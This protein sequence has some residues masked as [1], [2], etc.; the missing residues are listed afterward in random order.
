MHQPRPN[1]LKAGA[2]RRRTRGDRRRSRQHRCRRALHLP[3]RAAAR[4]L[5]TDAAARPTFEALAGQSDLATEAVRFATVMAFVDGTL[6]NAK[7][8]AVLGLAATLGVTA[9]FV[10]DVAEVAQGH[11]RD[12]TAHMIRANLESL[13]GTVDDR[14]DAMAWLLPYKT[15]IRRWPRASMR[16]PICPT[17][18]SGTPSRPSTSPTNTRSRA[19][20]RRS[21]SRSRRRTTPAHLW[22]A[23]TPRRAASSW[24]RP[25]RPRCIARRRCPA[26]C[27]R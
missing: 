23:T 3:A 18:R 11:L 12:A 1:I 8:K 22:R 14:R 10:T 15:P 7:L 27:C 24:C 13:T 5:R 17:R 9:D 2:R 19:K 20:S 21:I 16:W 25:S 6:D 4:P 26:M